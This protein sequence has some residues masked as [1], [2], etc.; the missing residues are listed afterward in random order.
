MKIYVSGQISDIANIQTIQTAL[1][2]AGHT[3]THDWTANEVGDMRIET[4]EDKLQNS[5]E[6]GLR[7]QKDIEGVMSSDV[8]VVCTDNQQRGSGMY[9]ELGAALA[10][11]ASTGRPRIYAIGSLNHLSVFYLHP[12]V[13]HVSNVDE[14][15]INLA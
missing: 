12:A 7:A 13:Q 1:R 4:R 9:A 10:C 11:H 3:I 15:I 2:K 5:K 14:L 8:F 6:A